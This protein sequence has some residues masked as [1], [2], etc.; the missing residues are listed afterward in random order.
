M[1]GGGVFVNLLFQLGVSD[2]GGGGGVILFVI[3]TGNFLCI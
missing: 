3:P 1:G 2:G